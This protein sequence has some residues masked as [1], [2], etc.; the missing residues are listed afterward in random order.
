MIS[1]ADRNTNMITTSLSKNTQ[2]LDDSL[3][4]T[5]S[6]NGSSFS[7]RRGLQNRSMSEDKL[8]S[9]SRYSI[10]A[11]ADRVTK[12]IGRSKSRGL[13]KS[14]SAND[15]ISG[16]DAVLGEAKELSKRRSRKKMMTLTSSHET[17]SGYASTIRS[18][19]VSSTKA[20][21]AKS[22]VKKVRF[23]DTVNV[24]EYEVILTSLPIEGGFP[25]GLGWNY[26]AKTAMLANHQTSSR[27]LDTTDGSNPLRL[28]ASER[29]S[30][31]QAFNGA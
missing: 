30:K 8:L 28:S 31:V 22:N 19:R 23:L 4:K 24:R 18:P 7:R 2:G 20:A 25:L 15:I 6:K 14:F 16:R 12:G 17:S 21:A 3:S 11:I 5:V 27:Q 26:N 13:S 10:G 1:T 29:K 9:K